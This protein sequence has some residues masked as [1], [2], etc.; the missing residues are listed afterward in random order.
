MQKSNLAEKSAPIDSAAHDSPHISL[1]STSPLKRIRLWDLPIR[2]FHWALVVAVTVALI[3]GEI[4]AQWI[5]VHG[6][7]GLTIVGLLSFRLVWGVI[8][9]SYARFASFAPTWSALRRYFKG[10]WH[11]VGHNP[12][13]ALSV[14]ALLGIL[15]AQA[16]TGLFANDDIDFTGPLF[17][18]VEEATSNRLTAF[19]QIISYGIFAILALHILAIAFYVLIKKN[20]LVKPMVTGWKEVDDGKLATQGGPI[21]LTVALI[22]SLAVVYAVSGL[23]PR[24]LSPSSWFKHQAAA[25]NEAATKSADKAADKAA[26]TSAA[27]A[28]KPEVAPVTAEPKNTTA[29]PTKATATW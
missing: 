7:A 28:E 12:L 18:L 6:K 25:P 2:I 3:T 1:I 15:A 14:F 20:N 21:A 19:H 9:S 23:S 27:P 13:G 11:G 16:A 5:G 29:P 26:D 8:G 22:F 24:D 17:N 10:Q 4:G